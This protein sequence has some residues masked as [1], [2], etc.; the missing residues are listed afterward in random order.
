MLDTPR[1]VYHTSFHVRLHLSIDRWA[2]R[3]ARAI[4]TINPVISSAISA[5]VG[6]HVDVIEQGFDPEDLIERVQPDRDVFRVTYTGIFYDAQRPDS[7]L[8]D[9]KSVV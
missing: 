8:R 4:V 6:K 2:T 9:R 7:F 1:I 5:R 3:P